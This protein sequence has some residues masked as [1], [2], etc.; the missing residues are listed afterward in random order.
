MDE[1]VDRGETIAVSA[2]TLFEIGVT[3]G[4]DRPR[5]EIKA[6][7]I[8]KALDSRP[9]F[10]IV[11]ITV[12]VAMEVALVGSPLRDAFDRIIVCTA[13][14]HQLRLITADER[15]IKSKLVPVVD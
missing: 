13:R 1:A 10:H 6:S 2:A 12:D 11:P 15:I 8:L 3:F 4:Y 9:D 7:D 14:V 5:T